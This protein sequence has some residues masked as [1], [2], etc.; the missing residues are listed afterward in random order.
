MFE[1]PQ[2]QVRELAHDVLAVQERALVCRGERDG[3]KL[4]GLSQRA[5]VSA[6]KRQVSDGQDPVQRRHGLLLV[7]DERHHHGVQRPVPS[8]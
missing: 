7:V 2:W 1:V 3:R 4:R 8:S 5:P 6:Q